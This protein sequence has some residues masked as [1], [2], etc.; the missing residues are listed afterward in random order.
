MDL[1]APMALFVT[2][3]SLTLAAGDSLI[4]PRLHVPGNSRSMVACT[5]NPGLTCVY[6]SSQSLKRGDEQMTT[7]H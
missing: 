5:Q 6:P 7:L 2:E 4:L 1:A 3:S